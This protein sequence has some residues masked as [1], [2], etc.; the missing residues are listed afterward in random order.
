MSEKYDVY[1]IEDW[2]EDEIIKRSRRPDG[3]PPEQNKMPQM[4]DDRIV[5]ENMKGE[6]I[7]SKWITTEREANDLASKI[8]GTFGGVGGFLIPKDGKFH[9]IQV[10]GGDSNF[11]VR[12]D[13]VSVDNINVAND[14]YTGDGTSDRIIDGKVLDSTDNSDGVTYSYT[15]IAS[16]GPDADSPCYNSD[17]SK[18]SL[19]D[20]IGPE[21]PIDMNLIAALG[22]DAEVDDLITPE[23]REEIKMK[24]ESLHGFANV[25]A[26]H[27]CKCNHEK[28]NHYNY[29]SGVVFQCFDCGKIIH[30]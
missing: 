16:A 11:D 2:D 9:Q 27:D 8:V 20:P 3:E 12:I 29:P 30:G 17:G 13:G 7:V 24:I 18:S 19:L 25:T 4:E 5:P 23:L 6:R 21:T 10:T 28:K 22:I 15:Y 14:S 26:D 1:N